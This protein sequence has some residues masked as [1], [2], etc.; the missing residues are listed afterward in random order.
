MNRA[1]FIRRLG[2]SLA[3][4]LTAVSC[5]GI[6]EGLV[7][8]E[9][10]L[11]AGTE[12]VGVTTRA[13]VPSPVP[14]EGTGPQQGD[15]LDA[16]VLFS[17]S[18]GIYM[19]APEEPTYLP[20]HTF[21]HYENASPKDPEP[22]NGNKLKYPTN[23]DTVYCT[24][25]YPM[26]GWTVSDDGITASHP[27]DGST[28]LMFAEQIEGCW[29]S[30]FGR[31]TYRHL[32]SWLKIF[33]CGTSHDSSWFWGEITR[34]SISTGNEVVIELYN[35]EIHGSRITYGGT[36]TEFPVFEGSHPLHITI[37]EIGSMFACPALS[38]TITVETSKAG[39][40]SL[41]LPLADDKGNALTSIDQAAGKL[42]ILE[43]YFHPMDVIEGR[44][45]LK[46]WDNK[47]EN[48]FLK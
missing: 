48:I 8:G 30:H 39:T 20:C 17:T 14:Y 34:I 24:G 29:S 5:S 9:I 16:K 41:T 28:D 25:L 42:F 44:C 21:I 18:S 4:V 31:Q 1:G 26:E 43:L 22:Y 27:M 6:N 2:R 19:N 15:R 46:A 10:T 7:G 33:T 13:D 12:T 23:D 32:L 37:H 3:A 45:T 38:Y 36:E 40:K 35:N 47:E 11:S